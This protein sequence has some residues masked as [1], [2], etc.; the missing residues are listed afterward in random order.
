MDLSTIISNSSYA[1]GIAFPYGQAQ[2]AAC[3]RGTGIEVEFESD[4][5]SGD[6]DAIKA[7]YRALDVPFPWRITEEGSLNQ[8][9]ELVTRGDPHPTVSA[10]ALEVGS[11]ETIL[12]GGR[13]F[14]SWRAAVQYHVD[15]S[16]YTAA[17]VMR[18]I[19]LHALYEERIF[20][21]VA[22]GR[23][24]SNFCVP[25]AQQVTVLQ[26]LS[27]ALGAHDWDRVAALLYNFPKYSSLN[28]STIHRLGT[29]EHRQPETPIGASAV[30]DVRNFLFLFYD[31]T[32]LA[33]KLDQFTPMQLYF[34]ATEG[35]GFT[36]RMR[37]TDAY[38]RGRTLS[39]SRW[40]MRFLT[41]PLPQ[42]SKLFA[43]SLLQSYEQGQQSLHPRQRDATAS[44][45]DPRI[46]V[47]AD[48]A[49]W[50]GTPE[51]IDWAAITP[52]Q[53]DSAPVGEAIDSAWLGSDQLRRDLL[54]LQ[55]EN[56]EEFS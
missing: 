28:L 41:A 27:Y 54:R 52:T 13:A 29:V 16:D 17:D 31:L 55:A 8:G 9:M 53:R 47:A 15:V 23:R 39:P 34:R 19:V 36:S 11:L 35:N 3:N 24:E 42:S 51:P 26:D 49:S 33:K 10:A 5:C 12:N 46:A 6:M 25:W 56:N 1:S 48:E 4:N 7:Y 40:V 30:S 21:T 37:M 18:L 50:V 44:S 45:S 32:L 38:G 43:G 20:E 14:S 22:R 2:H